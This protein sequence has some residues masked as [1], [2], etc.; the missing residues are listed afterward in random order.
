[1]SA[2]T[3]TGIPFP[4][5]EII[6]SCIWTYPLRNNMFIHVDNRVCTKHLLIFQDFLCVFS[7]TFQDH[8][9]LFFMT[10]HDCSTERLLNQSDFHVHLQRVARGLVE[11]LTS[12]MHP[13]RARLPDGF[14]CTLVT[15]AI[16][17]WLIFEDFPELSLI[18]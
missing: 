6:P 12:P 9:C 7:R 14:W 18:P 8:L 10:F 2:A 1:M 11:C 13:D 17:I 5:T 15:N 16:T 3:G 4:Y